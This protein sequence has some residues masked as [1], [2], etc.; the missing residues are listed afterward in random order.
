M[1]PDEIICE[2]ID[3]DSPASS[4]FTHSSNPY[5]RRIDELTNPM[6]DEFTNP[7]KDEL[8][9]PRIDELTNPR[10]D[11]FTHPKIDEF[12]NPWIDEFTDSS[13]PYIRR[14]DDD[15]SRI[16]D[17]QMDS[18]LDLIRQVRT[19]LRRYFKLKL[20]ESNVCN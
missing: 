19:V 20:N 16:T 5:I 8:T 1:V 17:S 14:I 3:V 13:N 7:R 6:I 2:M 15:S 11:E 18:P 10:I 9:N 4:A 12:S